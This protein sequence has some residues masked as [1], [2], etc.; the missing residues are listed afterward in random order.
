M[1]HEIS[2]DIGL[3]DVELGLAR[4]APVPFARVHVGQHDE[5]EPVGADRSFLERAHD[6]V[7][8][9][10]NRQPEFSRHA[11]SLSPNGRSCPAKAGHPVIV[12]RAIEV[13]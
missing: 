12:A 1:V 6:L 5:I 10:G 2:P 8:T 9:A 13:K 11:A 7:I 3:A 4:H